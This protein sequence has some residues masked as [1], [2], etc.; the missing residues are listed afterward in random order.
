VTQSDRDAV[1]MREALALA[2]AAARAGEVPVGAVVVRDGE[3]IGRGFNAPISSRDPTAHAE[4][5]ALRDA[6]S[7]VGNYRLPG[8]EL[9]VTIEPCTMCAGAILHA[10][11][12]RV[13]FGAN[14]PKTGACGSV[15]D[16]FAEARLNHHATVEGGVLAEECGATVTRFFEAKRE[17]ERERR[18]AAD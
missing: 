9:F 6:A 10:R 17:A 2:E 14:D 3:I 7:R 16:L 4:I 1:L 5:A 11:I 8:C 15:V 12:A 13:V 18:R